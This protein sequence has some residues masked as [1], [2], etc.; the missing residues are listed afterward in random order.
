M[1]DVVVSQ[2]ENVLVLSLSRPHKKNALTRQ[3]YLELANAIRYAEHDPQIKVILIQ[4]SE[5]CFTAGNDMH[6][7]IAA[8]EK[9][10]DEVAET[11]QFMRA[12]LQC[13][14]PVVA[15]VE[16]LAI[17]IGTTLLL[18][19]DFVYASPSARFMMP[20]INLGLVPEYASSFILPKLMG[21]VKAAELLMLGESFTAVDA[22]QMGLINAVLEPGAL[23]DKIEQVTQSLAKKPRQALLQTKYLLKHDQ[24]QVTEHIYKEL[25]YFV[26]AMRSEAATE[27]FTAF[28]EKREPDEQK[29][30]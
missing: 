10:A 29:F 15:K 23:A 14:I 8:V 9:E 22:Q 28:L 17:G 1:S 21:H 4:G 24:Q 30:L 18:H 13:K 7:F 12:L 2:N 27:A 26:A 6:D 11:E 3:M 5:G 19:C 20:F 16:G 25:E